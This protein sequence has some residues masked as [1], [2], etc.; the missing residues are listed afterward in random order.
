MPRS[1]KASCLAGA[2]VCAACGTGQDQQVK[3]FELKHG[4]ATL[5]AGVEGAG[6]DLAFLRDAAGADLAAMALPQV[7]GQQPRVAARAATAD[8]V[9]LYR[10]LLGNR[11]P[12][13]GNGLLPFEGGAGMA[14]SAAERAAI[15]ALAHAVLTSGS[16]YSMGWIDPG[17]SCPWCTTWY[18]WVQCLHCTWTGFC[19]LSY[20]L[21]TETACYDCLGNLTSDTYSFSACF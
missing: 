14:L 13:W 15:T 12:E 4:T 17:G 1:V 20:M 11:A 2:L 7:V 19:Y 9:V 21:M 6:P 8:E 3:Q 18:T 10:A 16:G 5:I